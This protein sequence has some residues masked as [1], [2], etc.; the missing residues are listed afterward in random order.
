[1][2][3]ERKVRKGK[4]MERGEKSA[5]WEAE[6]EENLIEKLRRGVVLTGKKGGPC[7]P[8]L[9]WQ[10]WAPPS[11]D[12]IINNNALNPPAARKLAAAFWEFQQLYFPLSEMHR[13]VSNG[14]AGSESRLRRRRHHHHHYNK[15]SRD[16]GLD[17]SHFLA[18]NSPSSPDQVYSFSSLD[19]RFLFWVLLIRYFRVSGYVQILV[20]LVAKIFYFS[21]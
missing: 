17:L 21:P 8:V 7:T 19:L 11:H 6:K 16:N 5:E 1:M 4:R 3:R 18:D 10:H 9:S 20:V 13:S 2:E 14:A 12:T 15:L